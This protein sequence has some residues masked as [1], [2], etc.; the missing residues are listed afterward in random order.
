MEPTT[1]NLLVEEKSTL[2][3]IDVENLL[4]TLRS[5]IDSLNFTVTQS[6]F[7]SKIN[8]TKTTIATD[9]SIISGSGDDVAVLS[10][11]DETWRFWAGNKEPGSAPFRVDKNGNVY[12]SSMTLTGYLQVGQAASDTASNISG[13]SDLSSDLGSITA[14]TI[15]GITI[16]GGTIQTS[17]SGHRVMIT[18][19]DDNITIYNASNEKT[20]LLDGSQTDSTQ[21]QVRIG[22]GI[23]LSGSTDAEYAY[24]SRISSSGFGGSGI[25]T[26]IEALGDG[27]EAAL[28]IKSD[29]T[30]EWFGRNVSPVMTIDDDGIITTPS[31]TIDSTQG[32]TMNGNIDWGSNNGRIYM[33]SGVIQLETGFFNLPRMTGATADARNDFRNGSMYYRTDGSPANVIRV[34]LNGAWK[35]ITTS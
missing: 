28:G 10:G 21:S 27:Q 30:F 15:T 29:G 4:N 22:G 32:I 16:T 23:F 3:M 5:Q 33:N 24:G 35:T 11:E 20:I 13:L 31:L 9:S 19:A 17:A 6:S 26:F 1:D 14:G 2:S 8:Q 7:G 34:Y 25:E 18:G 12:A